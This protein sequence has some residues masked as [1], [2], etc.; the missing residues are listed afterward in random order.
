MEQTVISG[1]S[2]KRDMHMTD[3]KLIQE[4]REA[5][6][7][8]FDAGWSILPL[9]NYQKNPSSFLKEWKKYQTQRATQE[10]LNAW[11]SDKKLTGIALVCGD[12]SQGI[13]VI[14]DDSYETGNPLPLSS[15]LEDVS[16]SGG[17]HLYF[18]NSGV[19]NRDDKQGQY[20]FE[21]RG[22]GRI[23]VLPP[24]KVYN[25][26]G[27]I[28]QYQWSKGDLSQ[29]ASLPMLTN[30]ML[31]PFISTPINQHPKLSELVNISEG[32]RHDGLL[33]VAQRAFRAYPSNEWDQAANFIRDVAANYNPPLPHDEVER[34][35]KDGANFRLE[36]MSADRKRSNSGDSQLSNDSA[37]NNNS[38]ESN[39]N[40]N[41]GYQFKPQNIGE[42]KVEEHEVDYLWDGIIAKGRITILA[43]FAK[44]GKT[45]L[46]SHLL[47]QMNDGGELA[48]RLVS[49]AKVLILTE[50][51]QSDWLERKK[52]LNLGD[53]VFLQCYPVL[54][55][56]NNQQ[57]LSLIDEIV[58]YCDSKGVELVIFDTISGMWSVEDENNSTEINKAFYGLRRL[59]QNKLAVMLVHHTTKKT[60]TGGKAV[61][62]S[63]AINANCDFIAEFDRNGSS[64]TQRKLK[65]ISRLQKES[66][67][68]IELIQNRYL[69]V[70]NAKR[71][72]W[73]TNANALLT[74]IPANEPGL[75]IR[76]L[77]EEWDEAILGAKPSTRAVDRYIKELIKRGR[78]FKGEARKVAK[79]EAATYIKAPIQ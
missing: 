24:S 31:L 36:L 27:V 71:P 30:E 77:H 73:E 64:G 61:R 68:I 8:Y 79:T 43:A 52:E 51:S 14:D 11:L 33:K 5:A 2:M 42:L 12:V 75:T 78:V 3:E 39:G 48:D 1:K 44:A 69:T 17:R 49:P 4:L 6:T 45:T 62:G 65:V 76:E 15:V 35:I 40:R 9:A 53:N 47:K 10:E 7:K 59:V 22:N 60:A 18:K 54:G 63:G 16:A 72:S 32:A 20:A 70:G 23:V 21:I 66:E 67:V 34:I 25:K 28:A 29:L 41:A 13:V 57:W 26:Q 50:E 38:S 37:W 74:V 58:S 55:S 19:T 46:I 56:L